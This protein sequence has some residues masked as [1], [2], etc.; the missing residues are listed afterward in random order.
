MNLK[1]ETLK[2]I[3]I[4]NRKYKLQRAILSS[5]DS[6][7]WKHWRKCRDS[8]KKVATLRK[9]NINGKS[10]FVLYRQYPCDDI[11]EL[12]PFNR[13]YYCSSYSGLLPYQRIAVDHICSS[14][15]TYGCAI[16][17]SDTGT[18]KTY[19]SLA[20]SRELGLSPAILC[21]FAGISTW[22][23]ACKH[24]NIKP[25]FIINW[26]KAKT[27]KF[28]YCERSRHSYSGMYSFKWKLP[29][30]SLLIFDEAHMA[31]HSDSQNFALHIASKGTP[32]I[33]LSATFADRPERLC[34]LFHIL[35]LVPVENFQDWLSSRGLF[36]NSYDKQESLSAIEDMIEINKIFYPRYGYRLSTNDPEVKKF[37][38]D[39][40]IRTMV[41]S[42]DAKSTKAQNHLYMEML[43]KVEK[44]KE[45]R[46]NA[47][48]LVEKLRYRQESELLKA[49]ALADVAKNI[50]DQDKAVCIF[51]NFHETLIYLSKKL[52][53]KSLIF[54]EQKK[55][56]IDREKVIDDFQSDK[57][58]ILISMVS[59]GGQ[60]ISLQDLQG[61]RPRVSL[62]CPT[63]NPI[64]LH[65]VLGRTYRAKAKSN[66]VAY[67][68]YAAKTIE[69][70]VADSVN[71]KLDNIRALNEGDLMEPDIFKL[72]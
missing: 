42:L 11:F 67:L 72:G 59:A 39:F 16:D 28:E 47:D 21:R 49:E 61:N 64:D 1:F 65:Q 71:K 63:Y 23:R 37:F 50:L 34:N 33:S 45:L 4:D 70:S 44:Y 2:I 58:N 46:R 29:K 6:D 15:L 20:V 54:G 17:G 7:F 18:G 5:Q 27:G 60:S 43:Q 35:G 12:A 30:K 55:Y 36:T 53:T 57:C 40:I 14:I 69:E 62:I 38:P 10:C 3:E 13:Q 19:V 26:E 52:A 31:N 56:G 48:V 25:I 22:E 8:I 51:V 66:P 9:E 32:S 24:F 68:V 41:L